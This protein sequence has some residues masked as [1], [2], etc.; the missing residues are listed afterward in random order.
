MLARLNSHRARYHTSYK[1]Q[2]NQ[3][4]QDHRL[5]AEQEVQQAAI[6]PTLG[7]VRAP[8][9]AEEGENLRASRGG[10]D[11]AAA[12][13]VLSR[14]LA[15]PELR[16]ARAARNPS[17]RALECRHEEPRDWRPLL[18]LQSALDPH[19]EHRPPRSAMFYCDVARRARPL[20][21]HELEGRR[22]TVEPTPARKS[23][24]RKEV[25]GDANAGQPI[26]QQV[27]GGPSFCMCAAGRR[28][29][30]VVFFLGRRRRHMS[31]PIFQQRLR[32]RLIFEN[33]SANLRRATGNLLFGDLRATLQGSAIR[34]SR[35]AGGVTSVTQ[36][37]CFRGAPAILV[38]NSWQSSN[39]PHR[40][41]K[42]S[43]SVR[44]P[45]GADHRLAA[46]RIHMM[47]R[48]LLC[49][50]LRAASEQRKDTHMSFALLR[51]RTMGKGGLPPS[52][53]TA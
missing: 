12:V 38:P 22:A 33:C 6:S 26:K 47:F 19:R 40:A 7:R 53:A 18:G 37:Y 25:A 3:H 29:I 1:P 39:R 23:G 28:P 48:R 32:R 35:L 45:R 36:V 46:K 17:T 20:N 13:H 41:R 49:L 43:V 52:S 5:P 10:R 27:A 4:S 14:D 44:C 50:R 21:R 9:R 31:R 15:Q 42:E 24:L 2:S 30:S 8:C 34:G 51:I 16:S 11:R